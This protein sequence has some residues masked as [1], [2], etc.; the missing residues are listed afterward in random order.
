MRYVKKKKGNPNGTTAN[1][2]SDYVYKLHT[3]K[4]GCKICT[5]P[6]WKQN[7]GSLQK[8]QILC[9]SVSEWYRF[10]NLKF[11]RNLEQTNIKSVHFGANQ[12]Y[13]FQ[14]RVD[15]TNFTPRFVCVNR[16]VF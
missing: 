7:I 8:G 12:F 9:W 15:S 14:F 1:M 10:Q 11:D 13:L 16:S 2:K 6:M 4:S 5:F 3:E